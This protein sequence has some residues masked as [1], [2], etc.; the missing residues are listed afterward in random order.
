MGD[1]YQ[2]PPVGGRSL[3]AS[4]CLPGNAVGELFSRF[5][6]FSF[7]IQQRSIEDSAHSSRL[8]HFRK[9]RKGARPVAESRILDTLAELSIADVQNDSLWRD[10]IIVVA[11]NE[12]RVRLNMERAIAF[13]HR[14]NQ[15]VIAW[16]LPLDKESL[17]KVGIIAAKQGRS[18]DDLLQNLD[19]LTFYFVKGAPVVITE[20]LSANLKRANG[21]S[22]ILDSLVLCPS[23]SD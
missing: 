14:T 6:R 15:P 23:I 18:V 19:E 7:N 21:T 12:Q 17:L 9:A 3:I 8:E 4:T 11:G 2:L 5:E 22:G 20:N 16:R 10:A 1:P 13:A